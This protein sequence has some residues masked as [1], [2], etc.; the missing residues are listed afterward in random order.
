MRRNF[1]EKKTSTRVRRF[2]CQVLLKGL[3]FGQDKLYSKEYLIYNTTEI[4][5]SDH[6]TIRRK[7][8]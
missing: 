4:A 5:L 2:G 7:S 1:S 8:R 6:W 3:C